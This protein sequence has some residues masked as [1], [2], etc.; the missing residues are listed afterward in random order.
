MPLR[1]DVDAELAAAVAY[2][3]ARTDGLGARLAMRRALAACGLEHLLGR[4]DELEGRLAEL[5]L[6]A[7][8]FA[9]ALRGELSASEDS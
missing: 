7:T 1:T 2:E 4:I 8:R 5:E 3:E 9:T 6:R